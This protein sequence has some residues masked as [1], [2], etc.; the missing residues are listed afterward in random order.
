[1]GKKAGSCRSANELFVRNLG[2]KL[3]PDGVPVQHKFYL[4]REEQKAERAN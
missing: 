3:S 4:G 1:M 2:W